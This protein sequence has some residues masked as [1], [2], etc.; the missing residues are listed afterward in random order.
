MSRLF[1]LGSSLTR[2]FWPTWANILGRSFSQ[3]ENWGHA[4]VGNR[5]LLERLNELLIFKNPGPDD[6]V[7]VQWATPHRFDLHKHDS[8]E[9]AGWIP[10]GDV[11]KVYLNSDA[12]LKEYWNEY[13]YVMHTA[14]FITIAKQLLDKQ[15]CRWVFLSADDLRQDISKF[16]EFEKYLEIYDT[17]DWAP[18]MYDWFNQSGIQKKELIQ[19]FTAFRSKLVVDEHPTPIAHYQYVEQYLKDKL[20][21]QLDKEWAER[22]EHILSTATHYKDLRQTYI[23]KLDWDNIYSCTKGL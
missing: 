23:D 11:R 21:I 2:H 17:I 22:A 13:S 12:W 3:F 20:N 18:P 15:G 1:T 9:H 5:A 14:N 4:G 16:P 8:K 19:Q 10:K 6:V 7:I